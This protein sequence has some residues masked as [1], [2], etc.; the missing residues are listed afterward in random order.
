MLGSN[1]TML[2]AQQE[3]EQVGMSAGV[4][5][6]GCRAA[7]S[8]QVEWDVGEHRTKEGPTLPAPAARTWLSRACSVL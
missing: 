5:H 3:L 6:P 7:A 8:K 1:A 4:L 2:W